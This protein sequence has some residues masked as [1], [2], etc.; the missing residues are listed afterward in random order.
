MN[1]T[2]DAADGSAAPT[3]S[4]SLRVWQIDDEDL[5]VAKS[6]RRMLAI[7]REELGEPLRRGSVKR[8]EDEQVIELTEDGVDICG[9][10]AASEF[11]ERGEGYYAAYR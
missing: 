8:L 3:G 11:A 7:A 5:I 9:E 1:N 2:K 6:H 4:S 10:V